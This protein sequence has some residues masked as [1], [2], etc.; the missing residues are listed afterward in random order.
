MQVSFNTAYDKELAKLLKSNVFKKSKIDSTIE[1]F[2]KDRY[3]PSLDFKQI[4]NCS[5]IVNC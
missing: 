3:Y 2:I 5:R 1:L 4:K